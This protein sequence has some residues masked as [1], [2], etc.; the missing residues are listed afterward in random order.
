[1]IDIHSHLLPG[2]DDGSPSIEES[3]ELIKCAFNEG[4]TDIIVTPHFIYE[5]KYNASPQ[6][7]ILL[8]NELRKR[9]EE[10][11]IPVNIYLGNEVFVEE[12][13]L[14]L[15]KQGLFVTL[16]NSRYLLF[17]MSRNNY[18]HG[19]YDLLFELRSNGI[20]PV[21]AHP[22]RY[23]YLQKHPEEAIKLV[24]HGAL[25]Q[26]NADSFYGTYGKDAKKLFIYFIKQ[27]CASFISTDTHNMKRNKYHE[28]SKIKKDLL[29]YIKEDEIRKLVNDNASKVIKNEKI[30]SRYL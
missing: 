14:E 4:V 5:S 3:I 22:E 28:L 17:E 11:K 7:N 13:L 20:I 15:Y 27:H 19:I 29:K 24:E 12:N 16:N 8:L 30:E 21:L 9:L 23:T 1:M 6:N 2:I 10:E 26:I 18:Y 25:F